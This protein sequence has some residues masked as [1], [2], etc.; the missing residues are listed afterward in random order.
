VTS[1]TTF[2]GKLR[3]WRERRGLSQLALAG[4]AGIS[5]RHLSFL[6]LDRASPSREMVD[7]LAAALDIS[8]RQHNA[9]LLAAGFAPA[10]RQRDLAA[11]DL[12][13][14]SS[15]LDYMLAQQEP[16]PAVVVDRHWNLLES[17]A[18]AVRLV[19][20][21]VGPIAPGTALNLADALVAP[22][23]LR[24]FLANWAEVVR[25]FIR[26][27]EADAVADGLPETLALL[28]RLTNYK[29][30]RGAMRL[31]PEKADNSPVLAM[32]FRKGDANLR[33]FTTIATLGTPQDITLQELRIECFFPMDD[34][35]AQLLRGWAGAARQ[36]EPA[37]RP[38]RHR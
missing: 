27:I 25:H 15:A 13:E 20:F 8:F 32:H 10:W 5:Q 4:R 3:W 1:E 31:A 14:V 6:E 34:V 16:Y 23:V 30:V 2:A 7:R 28:E 11:P 18:G 36:A 19:E 35:T 37:G 24:P 21:L 33:L 12:A 29:G 9:L 38:P 26:S 17:N 22:D